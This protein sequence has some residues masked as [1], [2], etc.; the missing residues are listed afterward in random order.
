MLELKVNWTSDSNIITEYVI[1]EKEGG[2]AGY[3]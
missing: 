3:H 2:S 1:V